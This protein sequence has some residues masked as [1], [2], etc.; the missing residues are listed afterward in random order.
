MLITL[1]LGILIST[2][3]LRYNGLSYNVSSVIAYTSS[4][5]R[6]FSIENMSVVHTWIKRTLGYY[7]PIFGP[8]HYSES[9]L[10]HTFARRHASSQ[11]TSVNN[12]PAVGATLMASAC[13]LVSGRGADRASNC[14]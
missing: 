14:C 9:R 12:G 10:V 2:V 6:H 5:S 7:E 1:H 11:P 13:R 3:K 4:R 8:K